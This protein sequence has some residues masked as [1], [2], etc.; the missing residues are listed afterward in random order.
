MRT[1]LACLAAGVLLAGL[2]SGPADA[3]PPPARSRPHCDQRPRQDAVPRLEHLLRARLDVR[4]RHDQER[5]GLPGQPWSEGRRL[6]VRLA[7]R[8]LVVRHPRRQGRDHRRRQAVALG[9][10]GGRGLHPQ[11]R[12]EGR[13]LHRSARSTSRTSSAPPPGTPGV[14]TPTWASCTASSGRTCSATSTTT[15]RTRRRAARAT[16]TTPTTSA[17]SS[18]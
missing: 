18:A 4:L 13:H 1:P 17:P 15:P 2:L 3:A 9:N 11:R 7:R 12:P 14:R 8:R 16:G 10:E 5:H 6:P